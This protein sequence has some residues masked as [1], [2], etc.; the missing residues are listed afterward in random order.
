MEWSSVELSLD[1]DETELI[2]E[3]L[4]GVISDLSPEIAD[5]DN[6]VYR[7]TLQ[8]RR[9]ALRALLAKLD[10]HQAAGS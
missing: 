7:R 6:P 5:T 4:T 3:V 10:Q 2:R 9:V 1:E 8:A